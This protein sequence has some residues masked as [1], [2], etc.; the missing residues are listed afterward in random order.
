MRLGIDAADGFVATHGWV[1]SQTWLDATR[2][3]AR[4]TLEARTGDLDPGLPATALLGDEPWTPTVTELLGLDAHEGRLYLPGARPAAA[5]RDDGI[6]SRLAESGLAPIALDA[7]LARQL[8]QEGR[9]VRLGDGLAIGPDAYR[10]FEQALLDEHGAAGT[11]TLAGFR[12][13]AG[14]SRRVAQ[15]VLERFDADRITLRVGNERRL[16]RRAAPR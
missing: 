6:D 5:G 16:R 3:Q 7:A 2:A 14:V 11:V 12:D 15:L 8:E 1:C 13:R 9:L 10:Q 4:A